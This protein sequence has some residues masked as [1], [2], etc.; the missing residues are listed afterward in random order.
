MQEKERERRERDSI[1]WCRKGWVSHKLS[2]KNERGES[3][4]VLSKRADCSR[5]VKGTIQ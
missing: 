3:R 5:T 1:N 4:E 2:D